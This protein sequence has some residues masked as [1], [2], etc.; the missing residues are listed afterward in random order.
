MLSETTMTPLISRRNQYLFV[1]GNGISI[2]GT[3]LY[4][5][6]ISLYVLNTTGSSQQFA[7]TLALGVMP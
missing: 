4:T 2:I 5:F 3:A 1:G 6:A 7:I